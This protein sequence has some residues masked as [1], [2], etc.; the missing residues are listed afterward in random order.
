MDFTVSAA[1]V[2]RTLALILADV[3]E[4]GPA[5]QTGTG[6]AGVWLTCSCDN[7]KV[8]QVIIVTPKPKQFLHEKNQRGEAP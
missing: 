6:G 1:E 7:K 4:A 5:I 2:I 3:V 8:Q